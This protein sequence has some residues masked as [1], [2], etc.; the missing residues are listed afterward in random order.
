MFT[1]IVV[2]YIAYMLGLPTWCKGLLLLS[3]SISIG[4]FVIGLYS[5]GVKNGKAEN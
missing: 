3:V 5:A 4:K 1:Q 2:L